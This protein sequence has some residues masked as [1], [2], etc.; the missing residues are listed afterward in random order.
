MLELTKR[1]YVEQKT[2][3][4]ANKLDQL[5]KKQ[6]DLLK[7]DSLD[8]YSQKQINKEFNELKEELDELAKDN[9]KLKEPMEL[10]DV[11]DEKRGNRYYFKKV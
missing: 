5:S 10:P 11:E 2:M 4:I 7:Q 3:Q 6:E 8:L 1:F 9:E